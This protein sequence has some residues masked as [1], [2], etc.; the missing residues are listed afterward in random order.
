MSPRVLL[1]RL[2]RLGYHIALADGRL[3]YRYTGPGQPSAEARALLT[4]LQARKE[5]VV[6]F[7]AARQ[8][9]TGRLRRLRDR[10]LTR[11]P[12]DA[13]SGDPRLERYLRLLA[14][15]AAAAGLLPA[16]PAPGGYWL[17]PRPDLVTDH[18]LWVCLLAAAYPRDG[19]RPD[20][21]YGVLHGLR[22]LGARLRCTPE[23]LR[24]ERGEI[25]EIDYAAL[26]RRWL[27][28]HRAALIP[29]LAT[30]T[31]AVSA[32]TDGRG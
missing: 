20:G 11:V 12:K 32:H 8:D 7:L 18:E 26:R 22:C 31:V 14:A 4:A 30:V 29:L 5:A 24:L 27:V 19:D 23:G 1:G 16:L 2:R 15:L 3:T 10:A 17:D 13:R 21:L 28:P 9:R 25:P 6:A